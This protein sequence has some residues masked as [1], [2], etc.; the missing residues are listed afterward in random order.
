MGPENAGFPEYSG[1]IT[2]EQSMYLVY[3]PTKLG[4]FNGKCR[5]I[6]HTWMVWLAI[7]HPHGSRLFVA[8]PYLRV[9]FQGCFNFR[10]KKVSMFGEATQ[11][12]IPKKG[13]TWKKLIVP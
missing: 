1:Q 2:Q 3:L 13:E 6:N 7:F 8:G 11:V 9:F 4:V 5:S 10:S 12:I